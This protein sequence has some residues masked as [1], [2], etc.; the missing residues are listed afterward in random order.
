MRVRLRSLFRRGRRYEYTCQLLFSVVRDKRLTHIRLVVAALLSLP[1]NPEGSNKDANLSNFRN[2]IIYAN[3]F[4]VSQR[5]MLESV[6][7]VTVTKEIDWTITQEPAQERYASGIKEMQEGNRIGFAKMLYTRV[8]YPD[9]SGD[10]EH[11]KGTINSLLGLPKEDID[12]ATKAAIER[13][14]TTTWG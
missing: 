12:E 9:G 13:S 10:F 6:L 2:K 3:S 7:R 11:C 14:K 5:D 4:T 8:F 1:I